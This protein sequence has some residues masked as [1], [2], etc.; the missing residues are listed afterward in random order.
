MTSHKDPPNIADIAASHINHLNRIPGILV[1]ENG[2]PISVPGRQLLSSKLILG[3]NNTLSYRQRANGTV[4]IQCVDFFAEFL[5]RNK[6][7]T[8]A[9]VDDVEYDKA[10]VSKSRL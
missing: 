3:D 6:P 5:P 4:I 7:N 10:F 9:S 1:P 8:P 2:W